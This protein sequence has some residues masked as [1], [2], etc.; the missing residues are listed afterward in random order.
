MRPA[1]DRTG[2]TRPRRMPSASSPSRMAI[3]RTMLAG[4]KLAGESRRPPTVVRVDAGARGD[5]P[6]RP[7]SP[8]VSAAANRTATSNFR[9]SAA[10]SAPSAPSAHPPI[11]LSA[12]RSDSSRTTVPSPLST[13]LPFRLA[14]LRTRKTA[15]PAPATSRT[16]SNG[17]GGRYTVHR[18]QGPAGWLTNDRYPLSCYRGSAGIHPHGRGRVWEDRGWGNRG[19]GSRWGNRRTNGRSERCYS[20]G[21]AGVHT[22]TTIAC[23]GEWHVPRRPS[24]LGK[25]ESLG[26]A[27]G[28]SSDAVRNT[29]RTLTVPETSDGFRCRSLRVREIVR[30]HATHPSHHR[31]VLHV[32]PP[33]DENAGAPLPPPTD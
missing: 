28:F 13:S 7:R 20:L 5:A 8:G 6:K 9:T 26:V 22:Q 14:S 12:P 1:A 32:T 30:P 2:R 15:S 27:V 24:E 11:A 4:Y 21:V 3:L 31:C 19:G 17:D 33:P 10:P 16:R 29:P 25:R 23:C 18:K